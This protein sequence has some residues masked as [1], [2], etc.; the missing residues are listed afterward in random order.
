MTYRDILVHM[1]SSKHAGR[2][3]DLAIRLATEHGAHLTGLYVMAP[4]YIP[5]YMAAQ[6][7]AE[8]FEAQAAM[9]R[10]AADLAGAAFNERTAAAGLSAE[11]RAASGF[12]ADVVS[13]QARYASLVIMGQPDPEDDAGTRELATQVVMESGRPVL[14]VPWAGNFETLGES[15]VV[16]WN[17]SRESA[18]AVSD[19]LPILSRARQVTVI[20]ASPG[21]GEESESELPGA[22]IA[23]HLARCD[24]EVESDPSFAAD[25]DPAEALLSRA[26]DLGADLIVMGAWGHS[27]LRELVTGGVTR[28]MLAHMTVPV[29]MSH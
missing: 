25:I 14:L 23:V 2:R 15:V 26:A 5:T 20:N 4:P 21:T 7:S 29:L 3:L 16:A 13:L 22:D 18:R 10:E 24:V 17:A 1:D 19:A 28:H 11:W 12:P 27:R 8:V 6:L 9:A